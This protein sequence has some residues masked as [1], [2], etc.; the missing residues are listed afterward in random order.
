VRACDAGEVAIG[1]VSWQ[2]ATATM[3]GGFVIFG[4][5]EDPCSISG[6]V[7]VELRGHGDQPLAITV[8]HLASTAMAPVVLLPNLGPPTVDDGNRAGRAGIR[9]FWTNWCG[10]TPL[11]AL[12]LVASIP[13]VGSV[14]APAALLSPPRCDAPGRPSVLAV[15]PIEPQEPST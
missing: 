6:R 15:G 1:A 8:E 7:D 13:R 12:T 11:G 2:G 3:A 9:L 4:T 5:G 14:A 10:S